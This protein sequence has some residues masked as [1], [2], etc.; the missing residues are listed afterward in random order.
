MI[1]TSIFSS[2]VI[3]RWDADHKHC[4]YAKISANGR[5]QIYNLLTWMA[6]T[7]S[8][9]SGW[10]MFQRTVERSRQHGCERDFIFYRPRQILF[11]KS[12]T[13]W[14]FGF[15]LADDI[16]LFRVFSGS[17]QL[18]FRK[19]IS[20][21]DD[22]I[23]FRGVSLLTRIR[24]WGVQLFLRS[25]GWGFDRGPGDWQ[26]FAYA[27]PM[28][29]WNTKPLGCHGEIWQRTSFSWDSQIDVMDHDGCRDL[30]L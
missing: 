2:V 21:L 22:S 28:R 9:F 20:N 15:C 7:P 8:P 13:T 19:Y 1:C 3:L 12:R 26:S 10:Y 29:H 17:P 16:A 14:C 4:S 27:W 30:G 23:G 25:S 5:N 6:K 18:E 11:H 24:E